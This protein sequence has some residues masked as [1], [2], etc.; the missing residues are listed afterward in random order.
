VNGADILA[1]TTIS[2]VFMALGGDKPKSGR[3]RAFY[4][5][6]DN[7]QAVSLD[8]H[9]GCW[10][11]HRNHIGGGVLDLIQ[12]VLGCNRAVA[13]LWL[14]NF[15][16]IPLEGRPFTTAQREEYRRQRA[17]AER[18]A[19]DVADFEHGL[20]LLLERRQRDVAVVVTWLLSYDI[21]PRDVFGAAARDRAVLRSLD[22]DSLV[23]AYRELPECV[24]CRFREMGWQ[25]RE[26][27]E[28][29]TQAVVMMLAQADTGKA[30]A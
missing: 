11:D 8:D 13:L 9:K 16:G 7:P 18:L 19:Q 17:K 30:V 22:A 1:A 2:R 27:A 5:D 15:T 26:H 25:A 28:R 10:F 23:Q 21:D 12:H 3:A 24:R 20:E 4:R 6:G 14:S 29:I